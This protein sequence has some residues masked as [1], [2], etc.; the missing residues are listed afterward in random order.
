M[1]SSPLTSGD[2]TPR[3]GQYEI[4]GPRGGHTGEERTSTRGN[5]LPP[6]PKPGQTFTFV[7]PTK[8]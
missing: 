8:H 5:P 3:S 2:P 4:R 1:A 7:D 6:T